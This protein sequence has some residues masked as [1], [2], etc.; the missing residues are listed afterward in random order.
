MAPLKNLAASLAAASLLVCSIAIASEQPLPA[1][2][3]RA[4]ASNNIDA[5]LPWLEQAADEG[6]PAGALALGKLYRLGKG[7]PK[8]FDHALELLRLAAEA[9]SMEGQYLLA[10]LYER[11][12]EVEQARHWYLAAAGQGHLRA[13]AR[14]DALTSSR[15]NTIFEAIERHPPSSALIEGFDTNQTNDS[16]SQPLSLA[17]RRDDLEWVKLLLLRGAN[18]NAE[19]AMQNTALHYAARSKE[20]SIL[21][22]LLDASSDAQAISSKN[23]K[24]ATPLHLAVSNANQQTVRILVRRGAS[25]M[26]ADDAG[27]TPRMLA[28]RRS[29]PKI[30]ALLGSTNAPRTVAKVKTPIDDPNA[31]LFHGARSGKIQAVQKAIAAKADVNRTDE[32]GNRPLTLASRLGYPRIAEILIQSGADVHGKNGEGQT[33]LMIAAKHGHRQVLG[34]LI[35]SN[36]RINAEDERGQTA[37]HLA[38]L[39]NCLEC[40]SSLIDAGSD[41]RHLDNQGRPA[42]LLAA[43]RGFN[44]IADRL[45]TANSPVNATDADGRSAL[46]WVAKSGS[47]KLINRLLTRGATLRADKDLVSPLHKA[48]SFDRPELIQALAHKGGIDARTRTGNTALM[49]AAHSNQPHAIRALIDLG[50]KIDLQNTVG[51][52][53]LII[54]TA[55]RSLDS[56]QILIE[57][58]ASLSNRNEQLQS[59]RV[60]IENMGDPTWDQMLANAPSELGSLFKQMIN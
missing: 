12:K 5:A 51:D 9:G 20:T 49:L 54:A 23:S 19:D 56:A 21:T 16:G 42:L 52:T 59:A 4:L 26:V 18:P 48:V 29:D 43:E 39:A 47:V 6:D 2:V 15:P 22:A 14:H 40:T 50:A 8:N 28:E 13:Q 34:Q 33:P 57:A 41:P 24:G 58:G 25:T 27:W 30:M 1:D 37:L 60:L 53:A 17:V 32:D 38:T 3:K 11:K 45:L 10:G 36:A 44:D 31:L 35:A 55:Q 7:V 46:W